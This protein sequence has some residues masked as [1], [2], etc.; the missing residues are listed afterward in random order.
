MEAEHLSKV[1]IGG[2]FAAIKT[3]ETLNAAA[4]NSSGGGGT[5][6]GMLGAGIGLG[7]GLPI[8]QQLGQKMNVDP[9]QTLAKD[10]PKI[11]IAKLKDLYDSNL[12]TEEEFKKKKSEILMDI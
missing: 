6:G 5:V 8:G 12:I 1:T 10:D 7:A 9:P 3:F 11:R 4:K 2:G